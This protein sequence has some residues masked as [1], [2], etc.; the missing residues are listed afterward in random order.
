MLL[1]ARHEFDVVLCDLRMPVMDGPQLYEAL[2]SVN[3]KMLSRMAFITGDTFSGS[4]S[5][6]LEG[7]GRP[8][9]Q[10]PFSPSELHDLIDRVLKKD[11]KL[12]AADTEE[13]MP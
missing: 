9:I 4:V 13:I 12:S 6:F 8:F 2:K 10:K 11:P 3:P 1:L 7:T 5:P